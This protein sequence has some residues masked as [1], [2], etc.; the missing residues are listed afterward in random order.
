MKFIWKDHE[1]KIKFGYQINTIKE[2]SQILF[3]KDKNRTFFSI[4]IVLFIITLGILLCSL[5]IKLKTNLIWK[6]LK[7]VHKKKN[8]N[9]GLYS[10]S[11]KKN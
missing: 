8:P 3:F 7:V 10:N 4:F 1:D 6:R 9:Q 11:F 5:G 2:Q